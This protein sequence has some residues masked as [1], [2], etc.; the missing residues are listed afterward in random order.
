MPALAVTALL[1][2][3][4]AGSG[5]AAGGPPVRPEL[6]SVS[7]H[8]GRSNGES[9]ESRASADGRFVAFASYASNLV[10]R[11]TNGTS[12]IFVRDRVAGATRRVSV[13]DAGAQANDFSFDPD[14]SADG[15][16]VAFSSDATN[17]LDRR[18]PRAQVYVRDLAAGRTIR[19]SVTTGG[20]S[21]RTGQLR[22]VDQRRRRYVAFMSRPRGTSSPA[23]RTAS[24]TSS[25]T[26]GP[27]TPPGWPASTRPA[28]SSGGAA[29][30]RG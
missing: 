7:S 29:R 19:V 28:I 18:G 13:S 2:P 24:S 10:P 22:P 4:L 17:L 25:C 5:M 30:S 11:D 15:R 14:I 1:A 9:V 27:P 6:V 12:D 8:G 23:T 26:I 16:Y 21:A 3:C 20:R